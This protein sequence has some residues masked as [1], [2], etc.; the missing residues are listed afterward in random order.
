MIRPTLAAAITVMVLAAC[1]APEPPAP[2]PAPPPP[3]PIEIVPEPL[4]VP[5]PPAPDACGA[6]E[7][8]GLLGQPRSSIPPPVYPERRRVACTTCPVT[9]DYREDRLNIYFDAETGIIQVV[10]CG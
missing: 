9:R 3:A 6:W 1:A 8:Q 4:F 2:P 7:L 5:P 10:N